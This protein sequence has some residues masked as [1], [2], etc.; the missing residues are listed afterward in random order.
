[1]ALQLDNFFGF[2]VTFN[3]FYP[4]TEKIDFTVSGALLSLLNLGGKGIS[5]TG[6]GL[7]T[8]LDYKKKV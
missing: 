7:F 4:I 5:A 6:T 2:H 1:M 3:G 8:V